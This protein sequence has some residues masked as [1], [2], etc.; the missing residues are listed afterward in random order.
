MLI[1]THLQQTVFENIVGNGEIA[2]NEQFLLFVQIES[3]C[4]QQNKC[5]LKTEILSGIGRKPCGEKEKMLINSIFSFS[6]NVF[7]RFLF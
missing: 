2:G 7:K 5:N 1:L 3:I 6:H 4:R